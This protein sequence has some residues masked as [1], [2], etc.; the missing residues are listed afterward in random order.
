M[1][2]SPLQI[3]SLIAALGLGSADVYAADTNG[4]IDESEEIRIQFESWIKDG[5]I[6]FDSV[7]GKPTISV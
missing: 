7:T 1:G 5:L 4:K 2:L 6:S 3:A